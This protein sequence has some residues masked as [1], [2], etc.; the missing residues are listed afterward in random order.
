MRAKSMFKWF[1]A[2]ADGGSLTIAGKPAAKEEARR[3]FLRQSNYKR[4]P[5]GSRLVYG[6][7]AAAAAANQVI[8]LAETSPIQPANNFFHSPSNLPMRVFG[9]LGEEAHDFSILRYA[10]KNNIPESY[11]GFPVGIYKLVAVA[12]MRVAKQVHVDVTEKLE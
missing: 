6:D 11:A 4:L 5:R 1:L 12:D 3:A 8:K 9:I 2:C 7:A 10:M